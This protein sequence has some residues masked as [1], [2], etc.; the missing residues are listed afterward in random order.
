VKRRVQDSSQRKSDDDDYNRVCSVSIS[1]HAVQESE[2][3][4]EL[5]LQKVA[6]PVQPEI[7][8][9]L[10]HRKRGN[11]FADVP[12]RCRARQARATRTRSGGS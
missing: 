9:F 5:A 3:T 8:R 10:K 4:C 6:K 2:A 11:L 7:I 12:R 1:F